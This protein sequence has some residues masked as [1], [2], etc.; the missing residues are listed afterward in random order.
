MKR[1]ARVADVL[2]CLLAGAV[3]LG[4]VLVGGF[5]IYPAAVFA[6]WAYLFC[7]Y[8][9]S[10]LNRSAL[11]KRV[12]V[13]ALSACF[14]A[15][16]FDLGARAV[17]FV[18]DGTPKE[19]TRRR[20]GPLPQ[21]IRLQP[22]ARFEGEVCGDL[23]AMSGRREWREYKRT[24]FI[25][26]RYGF[27][28][29]PVPGDQAPAPDLIVL[30]DSFGEALTTR[31]DETLSAVLGGADGRKVYNLSIG[32]SGPWQE[33]VN[34][35]VESDRLGAKEGA[36]VLWLLFSGNDLDDQYLP[37]FEPSQLPWRDAR[38]GLFDDARRFRGRSPLRHVLNGLDSSAREAVV[39][40]RFVDGRR[41]L[42]FRQYV[43]NRALTAEDVRRHQNFG[44][45]R[46][47][48]AAMG[49]LAGEKR[50]RVA[51][52]LV[53]SK[54]E[55]YSWVLDDAPAWSTGVGASPFSAAV[56][57]MARRN[58]MPF[59][60]LKPTLVRESR[61]VFEETGG[62]LWWADDS[63]WNPRAQRIAAETI[64]RELLSPPAGAGADSK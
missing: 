25:T 55:V 44:A 14:A 21:L 3:L 43:R 29:E 22:G 2:G 15:T 19:L 17:G 7:L 45:L 52:A 26:D 54:E 27:R 46:A 40:K 33:Y 4:P 59:L 11:P 63:H 6:G 8:A 20:W 60:D 5:D 18:L 62:L 9:F 53:P 51:V 49:R 48:F 35:L 39:E 42:F 57:D 58:G 56:E 64:R 23:S 12:S 38:G 61:S 28:N 13:V 36:V 16:A 1:H 41:L 10:P 32:S 37:Y 30:G 47:T 50:L 34:L 31:Q 24:L